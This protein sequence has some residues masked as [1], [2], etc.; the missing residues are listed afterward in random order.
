MHH[1]QWRCGNEQGVS[2]AAHGN[3]GD[4][5]QQGAAAAS[6][7]VVVGRQHGTVNDMAIMVAWL[8]QGGLGICKTVVQAS[9]KL[10][11]MVILCKKV[12]HSKNRPVTVPWSGVRD[13]P[14]NRHGTHAMGAVWTVPRSWQ[15]AKSRQAGRQQEHTGC[16]PHN[17]GNKG[18]TRQVVEA[19][20]IAGITMGV[21]VLRSLFVLRFVPTDQSVYG[22]IKM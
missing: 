5:E 20:G 22:N 2:S 7:G 14:W 10:L 8:P 1:A 6:Q 12:I 4:E 13:G 19:A 21:T 17:R 3:K 9:F 15:A 16:F 11:L 18:N